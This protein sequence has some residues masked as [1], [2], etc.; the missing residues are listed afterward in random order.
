MSRRWPRKRGNSRY[1]A[2]LWTCMEIG[3]SKERCPNGIAKSHQRSSYPSTWAGEKKK[4]LSLKYLDKPRVG[5]IVHHGAANQLHILA[6]GSV[7][8]RWLQAAHEPHAHLPE[9][10][11]KVQERPAHCV[12]RLKG[13]HFSQATCGAPGSAPQCQAS[14]PRSWTR[15]SQFGT[16]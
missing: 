12:Q 2:H 4:R 9:S 3:P 7:T 11:Y 1:V 10:W 8:W 6:K 15:E 16:S 13:C 5:D 14:M